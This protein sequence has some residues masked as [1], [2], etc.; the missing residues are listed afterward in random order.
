MPARRDLAWQALRRIPAL[1]PDSVFRASLQKLEDAVGL[2]GHHR[3]ERIESIR[4]TAGEFKRHR[5]LFDAD[6][7]AH[8]GL[9]AARRALQRLSHLPVTMRQLSLLY[10]GGYDVVPLDDA[11][12]RV[13]ARIDGTDS[14]VH[15][16]GEPA[17]PHLLSAR[18]LN[19]RRR[20][21]RK[22]LVQQ[23]PHDVSV[24]RE[25]VTYLR[26][27]GEH[28]CTPTGPHCGVCPWAASCAFA[29]SLSPS[30]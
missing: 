11:A 16:A 14:R 3:D 21:A 17:R 1:T 29:R 26:H 18:E 25:V 6:A 23:L 28:T 9:R 4:A 5:D 20:H 24:Y 30:S 27:H 12:A 13:V 8:A 15:S 10:A 7:F 2:A 22:V 19:A